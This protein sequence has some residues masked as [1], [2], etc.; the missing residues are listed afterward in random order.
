MRD[1]PNNRNR[2]AL[3]AL[4]APP[5]P[6]AQPARRNPGH[7]GRGAPLPEQQVAFNRVQQRGGAGRGRGQAFNLTKEEAEGSADVVAGN[8]LAN[9]IPIS[10]LFDSGASHCFVS[11]SFVAMHAL[12]HKDLGYPWD[13]STGNGVIITSKVCESCP[14]EVCGRTLV[15]DLFVISTGDYDLILGMT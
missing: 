3:P 8:L 6:Q 14:I 12:P 7:I 1:C 4:P 15:A 13:V 11:S 5:A 2:N 9:S 10:T